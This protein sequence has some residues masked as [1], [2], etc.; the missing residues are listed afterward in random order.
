MEKEK[1]FYL[2]E[3]SVL[4][5]VV[6]WARCLSLFCCMSDDKSGWF[7]CPD[8]SFLVILS[9]LG[10]YIKKEFAWSSSCTLAYEALL[11]SLAITPSLLPCNFF[12]E[13]NSDDQ[14]K[15]SSLDVYAKTFCQ[16]VFAWWS[17]CFFSSINVA[18]AWR[19]ALVTSSLRSNRAVKLLQ[20]IE[21]DNWEIT[22]SYSII[23]NTGSVF[24]WTFGLVKWLSG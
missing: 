10:F 13:S 3:T 18:L 11:L 17:S 23:V 20:K 8:V 1:L 21:S 19:S 22:F 14:R 5:K 16:W 12:Y 2:F 9:V 15:P 24:V 6:K 4:I 7:V